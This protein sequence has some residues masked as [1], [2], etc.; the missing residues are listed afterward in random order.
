MNEKSLRD[1]V[2]KSSIDYKRRRANLYR[3]KINSNARK[4]AKE[5]TTYKTGVGLNLDP[6]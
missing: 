6:S 3:R 5:G 2:R 1:K 4:E